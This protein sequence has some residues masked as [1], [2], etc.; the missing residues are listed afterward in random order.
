MHPRAFIVTALALLPLVAVAA[1]QPAIT[2]DQLSVLLRPGETLWVTDQSG[3]EVKGRLLRLADEA[4]QVEIDG[5]PRAFELAAVQRLQHREHD[6]VLNGILIGAGVG[7]GLSGA[8]VAALC[9]DQ[10]G[11]CDVAIG[12]TVAIYTAIGAGFGALCDGLVKGRR[13]VFEA[14]PGRAARSVTVGPIVTREARGVSVGLR[15]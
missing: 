15:F 1:Q 8:A 7:A 10:G 2:A 4:L 3:Q 14:P 6:S 5:A 13:T 9:S 12:A 11:E